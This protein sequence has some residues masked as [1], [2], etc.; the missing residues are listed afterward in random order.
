MPQY[1][2]FTEWP[3]VQC[4]HRPSVAVFTWNTFFHCDQRSDHSSLHLEK[5]Q[6]CHDQHLY[7]GVQQ[8]D[9]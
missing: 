2:F 9:L 3:P 6:F 7:S 8:L 5:D 1:V 4:V